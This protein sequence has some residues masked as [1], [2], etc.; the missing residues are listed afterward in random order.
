MS[1]FDKKLAR[2]KKRKSL[3]KERLK[4]ENDALSNGGSF[5]A[6]MHGLVLA[7]CALSLWFIS[8]DIV[9]TFTVLAASLIASN[10]P[11]NNINTAVF[12]R[13]IIK[14]SGWT[15]IIIAFIYL[16]LGG[17]V[18]SCAAVATALSFLVALSSHPVIKLKDLA[19]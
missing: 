16:F 14:C 2:K 3:A 1:T 19:N 4:A 11:L 13:K 6:I 9:I 15:L 7:F 10:C 5:F 8:K 17:L 12:N 18:G